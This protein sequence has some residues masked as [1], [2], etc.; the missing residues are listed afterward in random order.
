MAEIPEKLFLMRGDASMNAFL[1][2]ATILLFSRSV[3][4]DEYNLESIRKKIKQS[5]DNIIFN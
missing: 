4:M 2:A 3:V 1:R 5:R